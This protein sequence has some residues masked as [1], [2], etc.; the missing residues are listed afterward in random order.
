MVQSGKRALP[1]GLNKK[2][3]HRVKSMRG[4]VHSVPKYYP[5]NLRANF[6]LYGITPRHR[7]YKLFY[8]IPEE[9]LR[10]NG[11]LRV[12]LSE[13]PSRFTRVQR[14]RLNSDVEKGLYASLNMLKNM[15][16]IIDLAGSNAHLV[17][18]YGIPAIISS[19]PRNF[20]SILRLI[21]V[22]A[23]NSTPEE[24]RKYLREEFSKMKI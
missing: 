5:N 2:L 22:K 11:V 6:R 12:I 8:G 24:F 4:I 3:R 19:S 16:K 23:K 18:R 1:G 13:D 7:D 17:L 15:L 21:V 20:N 9:L 10:Y 14:A